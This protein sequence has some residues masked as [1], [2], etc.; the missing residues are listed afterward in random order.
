[1][2][3][4]LLLFACAGLFAGNAT[5]QKKGKKLAI[6]SESDSISYAYGASMAQQGL[7]QYIMQLGVITDVS[8]FRIPYDAEIAAETDPQKKAKMEK[9][10][11]AKLD[12]ITKANDKNLSMFINGITTRFDSKENKDAYYHGIAIGSQLTTMISTF[13][14]Q[15]YG[16]GSKEEL[17]KQLILSGLSD[18]L[19][20]E[21]VSIDDSGIL[22]EE[23]MSEMQKRASQETISEGEKFLAENGQRI[24][25]VTLPD[26][27][28][29]EVIEQGDGP[30]PTESDRVIVHYTGRLLDGTVFDSSVDRGEPATF[31]VTQVIKGWTEALQLMPV[32]SKWKLYIPYELGYGERG[33]GQMIKPYSTLI[34]EVELLGIE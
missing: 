25:I 16:E 27:L 1:M 4:I 34:F 28:Q 24:G 22:I 26:G 23:K 6:I 2:K 7:E 30:I 12:S 19:R 17:N 14:L 31:G 3:K 33:A 21:A 18:V 8:S 15:L 32:G 11:D 9:E 13:S 5:A 20:K 10:L 29:Y